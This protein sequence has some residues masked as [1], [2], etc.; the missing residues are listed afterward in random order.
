MPQDKEKEDKNHQTRKNHDSGI[1]PKDRNGGPEVVL[2]GAEKDIR[3]VMVAVVIL[4]ALGLGNEII[5]L[6]VGVKLLRRNTPLATD[7]SIA[8]KLWMM[9]I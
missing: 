8:M 3:M 9:P 4:L 2:H 5:N 1:E 7:Q 6:L